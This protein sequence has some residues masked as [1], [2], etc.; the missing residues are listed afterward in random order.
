[1]GCGWCLLP[2]NL[3]RCFL[4]PGTNFIWAFIAP[5]IAIILANIAFFVMAAVV[6]WK[7]RKRQRGEM[8]IKQVK[9]WLKASASLIVVLGVPWIFGVLLVEVEE[10]TPLAYIYTVLVAFQGVWIFLIFVVFPKQVRDNYSKLGRSSKSRESRN[11]MTS[12]FSS[13]DT[14]TQNV[15]FHR[16]V[17]VAN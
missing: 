7:H 17:I 14:L 3:F 8:N 12:N 11:T 1:M 2:L 10:L 4:N 9:S 5:V 15:G 16:F 13:N 6:M